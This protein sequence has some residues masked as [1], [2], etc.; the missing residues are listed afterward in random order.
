M[1]RKHRARFS[2]VDIVQAYSLL[3]LAD[4]YGESA[5]LG[6]VAWRL[7][8]MRLACKEVVDV[9]QL[10]ANGQAIYERAKSLFLLECQEST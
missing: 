10:S 7:R 2:R 5:Y 3:T 4:P 1:S 9:A 6:G 8:R